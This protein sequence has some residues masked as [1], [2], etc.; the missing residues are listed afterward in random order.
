MKLE[1]RAWDK[2]QNKYIYD[3]IDFELILVD[4][5]IRV[6]NPV[7][8]F[9]KELFSIFDI[10]QFTGQKDRKGNKIFVG[11]FLEDDFGEYWEVI[12]NQQNS[13]FCIKNLNVGHNAYFDDDYDASAMDII[14]NIYETPELNIKP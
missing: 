10:Q 11:D 13:C 1:F 9:A 5:D 7:I 2:E 3:P 6:K 14:G 8:G 12:F 4:V